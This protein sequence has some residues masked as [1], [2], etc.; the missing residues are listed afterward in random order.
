MLR[1]GLIEN[2]GAVIIGEPSSLDLTV[3]EKGVVWLQAIVK[4]KSGR[5]SGNGGSNAI[6]SM[7]S[8]SKRFEALNFAI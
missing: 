5:V 3:T 8:F 7:M 1:A 6:I 2:V 4:G